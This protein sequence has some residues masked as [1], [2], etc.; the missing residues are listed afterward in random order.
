MKTSFDFDWKMAWNSQEDGKREV[1]KNRSGCSSLHSVAFE[2]DDVDCGGSC[3][4]A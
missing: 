3:A 1:A 4:C 2:I